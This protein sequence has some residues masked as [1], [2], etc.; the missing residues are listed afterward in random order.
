M[1]LRNN[2]PGERH[3]LSE[4]HSRE[5]V[6]D[7]LHWLTPGMSEIFLLLFKRELWL[8]RLLTWLLCR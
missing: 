7:S 8:E 2:E 1:V 4:G 6:R 5:T 3:R